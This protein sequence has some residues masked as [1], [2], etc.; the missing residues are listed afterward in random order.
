[1]AFINTINGVKIQKLSS[2]NQRA[3]AGISGINGVI[4]P[5]AEVRVFKQQFELFTF[6]SLG[7]TATRGTYIL[8]FGFTNVDFWSAAPEDMAFDIY[9]HED[10][11]M[12]SG[13][14]AG[15]YDS[16]SIEWIKN[17][18]INRIVRSGDIFSVYLG[19]VV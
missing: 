13:S 15:V 19:N 6:S 14:V 7:G 16:V 17:T 10:N 18:T 4:L 11:Y 5:A 1:M 9:D 8:T 3:S 2:M 12:G